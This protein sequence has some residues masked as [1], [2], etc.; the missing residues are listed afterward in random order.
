MAKN[1]IGRPMK[2][3]VYNARYDNTR[4]VTIIPG[5]SWGGK[6]LLGCSIRFAQYNNAIDRFWHVLDVQMASPAMTAGFIPG[7]GITESLNE[8]FHAIRRLDWIV[9]SPDVAIGS[10]DDFYN[11]MI[12]N[13][14]RPVRLVLFNLDTEAC[15]EATIIPDFDWG[16]AGCLGCDVGGGFLHRIPTQQP[17]VEPTVETL[18]AAPADDSRAHQLGANAS[19]ES[20]AVPG[21]PSLNY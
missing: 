21:M 1:H 3:T 17:V 6:T 10:Q 7:K 18:M 4:E 9:G 16:G 11:L 13:Q 14:K 5:T 15:R 8:H 19:F 2:M 12:H 20:Q